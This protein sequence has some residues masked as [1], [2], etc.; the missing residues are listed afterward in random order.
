MKVFQI[1]C[2]LILSGSVAAQTT[3]SSL[4][5]NI[6][7]A[8]AST[9]YDSIRGAD[10]ECRSAITGNKNLEFGI[11]TNDYRT[12]RFGVYARLTIALNPPPTRL[13][14]DKFYQLE[15]TRKEL[16]IKE[17]IQRIRLMDSEN[18]SGILD[19]YK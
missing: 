6:P 13:D 14:C 4:S 2:L 11:V 18:I 3:S 8:S 12:D 5:L 1:F 15:L 17:L 16:E 19:F 9:A 7:S 10:V